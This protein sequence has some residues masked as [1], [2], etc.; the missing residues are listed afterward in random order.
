MR[1]SQLRTG[2]APIPFRFAFGHAAATRSRAENVLVEVRDKDGHCG[3]GEGCPRSYVTGEDVPGALAFL[4]Q[5]RAALLAI[6]GLDALKDFIAANTAAID[7]APSAFCAAELALLDLL[8]RQAGQDLEAFLGVPRMDRPIAV[9]AVYGSG[10]AAP[11]RI[12]SALFLLNHM[13]DSKLKLSG[14]LARDLPRAK[15]LARRGRVRLD[16]NNLWS[17]A[18]AALPALAVLASHAWAVE[19]PIR[20]RDWA[21]L[22]HIARETGLAIILD[23]SLLTIAD[24]DAVPRDVSIIPNLRVS[25]QGGL[26]RSLDVLARAPGPVIV[27]AQ[28]G[29]TSI[30]ARAGLALAHAAGERLQGFE[31]V[32]GPLLLSRDV[33]T[34]RLGF[35]F[36]GHVRQGGILG[37]PGSGLAPTSAFMMGL[38]GE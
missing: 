37:R 38:F 13:R 10:G 35:G 19:E 14:D 23:E 3:L 21:G 20:P 25:K 26:I 6:D 16:A 1:P 9:T 36:S 28:V 30:L 31:G 22:V 15:L 34:P 8:A 29:E 12:Q 27:G 17:D 18:E 5:N 33:S 4:A 24:V 11:F 2:S 32:Y 7:V